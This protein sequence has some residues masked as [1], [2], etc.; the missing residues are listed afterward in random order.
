M[1]AD[2]GR[3][4]GCSG[5]AYGWKLSAG[6]LPWTLLLDW[7]LLADGLPWKLKTMSGTPEWPTGTWVAFGGKLPAVCLLWIWYPVCPAC[8]WAAFVWKLQREHWKQCPESGLPCRQFSGFWMIITDRLP[9][10]DVKNGVRVAQ[11]AGSL[12][13]IRWKLPAGCL[14]WTLKM[15][16]GLPSRQAV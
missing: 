14:P 5:S 7:K 6:S 10:L 3:Y 12:A 15:V 2:L 13:T 4:S 11:Q 9:T 8:I 16:S 1:W